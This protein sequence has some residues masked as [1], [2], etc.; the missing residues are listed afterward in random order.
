M[1]YA[2]QKIVLFASFFTPLCWI[3][4]SNLAEETNLST[5]PIEGTKATVELREKIHEGRS[6]NAVFALKE[7]VEQEPIDSRDWSNLFTVRVKKSGATDAPPLLGEYSTEKNELLFQPRFALRP[8]LEYEVTVDQRLIQST[9]N[10]TVTFVSCQKPS[11]TVGKVDHIYP[12]AAELPENVL[13]FY[14]HFS[15]PMSRGD[16]Y[17]HIHLFEGARE[18]VEPFLELGEELWNESQTRFTLFVHPGRIKRGVKPREDQGPP[19][20]DGHEYSLKIDRDWLTAARKPLGESF[21]KRFKVIAADESQ[22][23]PDLWKIF[24]PKSSG[25]GTVELEFNESLDY[26]MLQR[27]ILVRNSVGQLL[28]GRVV[29]SQQERRWSF[30]PKEA[31]QRGSFQLEVA[32]NLE[33]LCG[34]SIAKA[35][36]VEMKTDAVGNDAAKFIAIEFDVK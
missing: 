7:F 8:D 12:T 15:E 23:R 1:R 26:A 10:V 35:F 4:Q 32:T 16:A 31:W 20:V 25:I 11:A 3:C 19:L 30:A 9:R 6:L 18:I 28:E 21:E 14:I 24:A 34:N 17:R 36:E 5:K 27:V 13:K 22:L 29:V 33:D 2:L